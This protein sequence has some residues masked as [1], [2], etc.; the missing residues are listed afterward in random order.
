MTRTVFTV[1]TAAL[2]FPISGVAFATNTTAGA[3][4]AAPAHP[5]KKGKTESPDDVVCK[6]VPEP[7]SRISNVRVCL[8]RGEW[9]QQGATAR[10]A[11]MGS[12]PGAG[13]PK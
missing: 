1:L 11:L 5:A 10:D 9:A 7:G 13:M 6:S 3:T 4:A 12:H 8:T 2:F